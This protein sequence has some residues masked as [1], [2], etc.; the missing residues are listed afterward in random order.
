MRLLPALVVTVLVAGCGVPAGQN[1]AGTATETARAE[2]GPGSIDP[3]RVK[4]IRKDLPAGDEVA[5]AR[6]VTSPATYWGMRSG[7]V[8]EP[9]QC[10]A[11]VNPA[12]GGVSRGLS[13]SGDG[14]QIYVVIAAAPEG[15]QVAPGPALVTECQQWTASFGRSVA[16][17]TQAPAPSI[18]E[19]DGTV[20]MTTSIRTL[21][22][23][24]TETDSHAHTYIAY[25]DAHLIF[26]TLI[27]DPGS[28][29]PPLPPQYA[30]DLLVKTVAA[31]RG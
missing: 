4:R 25:L 5:E 26:V 23:S 19:A 15:R 22:E 2:N 30:A 31:A 6:D 18:D 8:A 17:V 12:D 11:L 7:W 9:P 14:G 24:G 27:V 10:A 29:H 20:G 28:P 3:D 16:A 13:S 21:V 1:G